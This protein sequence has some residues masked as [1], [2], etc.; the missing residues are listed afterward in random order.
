MLLAGDI[1]GTKTVLALFSFAA[2]PRRPLATRQFASQT[3]PSLTTVIQAFL[4]ERPERPDQACFGVAGP[5]FQGRAQTTNL[6]WHIDGAELADAFA[7][8]RVTLLNDL[9]AVAHAIPLLEEPDLAVITAGQAEERG[10]IAVLAPGTG[11]GEAFIIWKGNRY[12]SLAT[13][14]G[15][16]SFAPTTPLQVELLRYLMPRLGHVSFE[17][18]CSGR[19]IPNLYAFLRDSGRYDEPPWLQQAL[20]QADDPTPV[21]FDGAQARED[22]LCQATVALFVEILGGEAGNLAL[23]VLATGGIY[24]GGGIPPRILPALQSDVFRQA[25]CHKGRFAGFLRDVPIRVILN[26]QAA[27]LGTARYGLHNLAETH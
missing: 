4:A 26:N 18:V 17:R 10:P 7:L 24:L 16:K 15:H 20:A 9:A 27:L 14:G 23:Q 19:G 25:F 22:P 2:G 3:Y 1:G 6:P 12:R 21:I 11:L 13:E 8:D 5:V